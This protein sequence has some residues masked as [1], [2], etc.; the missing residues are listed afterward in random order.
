[1]DKSG[2]NQTKSNGSNEAELVEIIMQFQKEAEFKLSENEKRVWW[3][4]V[5]NWDPGAFASAY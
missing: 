3:K 5:R 2:Q 1:M 4:V